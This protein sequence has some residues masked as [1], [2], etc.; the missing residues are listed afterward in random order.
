MS[1]DPGV[2]GREATGRGG[3]FVHSGPPPPH[4]AATAPSPD[5]GGRP[6]LVT[7]PGA[8]GC[9]SGPMKSPAGGPATAAVHRGGP[10]GLGWLSPLRALVPDLGEEAG[11]RGRLTHAA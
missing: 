8:W 9:I 4:T 11:G 2:K 7:F 10:P 1:G 6:A 5:P 3:P